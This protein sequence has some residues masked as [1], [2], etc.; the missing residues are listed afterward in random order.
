MAGVFDSA[1]LLRRCLHPDT[2]G[3]IASV[4]RVG[5]NKPKTTANW[6]GSVAQSSTDWLEASNDQTETR[7]WEFDA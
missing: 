5:K 4:G 7:R 3:P 2:V 1:V 6:M